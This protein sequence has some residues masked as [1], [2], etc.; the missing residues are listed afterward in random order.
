MCSRGLRCVHVY[1]GSSRYPSVEHGLPDWP[2]HLLL[3]IGGR[4]PSLTQRSNSQTDGKLIDGEVTGRAAIDKEFADEDRRRFMASC[5]EHFLTMH[6]EMKFSGGIIHRLLLREL[7]HNG[8]T[9]EMHFMSGTQSILMGVDERFKIPVWQFRLVKD[10]DAFDAFPWGAYVYRHSIHSFKHALDGRKDGFERRRVETYNIYGLSH[11]LLIFALE[12]IHELAKEVSVWRVTDLT[13]R[14]LKW[15]LTKQPKG[16]KLAKIFKARI[17]A[18]KELVPTPAER[19]APYYACLDEGGALTMRDM[20]QT[21]NEKGIGI[22]GFGFPLPDMNI[23]GVGAVPSPTQHFHPF[24]E[25]PSPT[26]HVRGVGAVPSP[27]LPSKSVPSER[28]PP[29]H[30]TTVSS[31]RSPSPPSTTV[32][33]EL[34]PPP[35]STSVASDRSP[36]PVKRLGK[37]RLQFVSPYTDPCRPKRLKTRPESVEHIF[38]PHRLVDGDHLP[39][40]KAFKRDINGE[41]RDVDVLSPIT[42]GWFVRMQSNFMDLEDTP[43]MLYMWERM[44]PRDSHGA[45]STQGADFVQRW[46]PTLAGGERRPLSRED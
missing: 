29:P 11:A 17:F 46:G 15:E 28:S 3:A 6:R 42:A 33:S 16:K 1:L 37:R 27:P 9:D 30:S 10:L 44:L 38:D 23:C 2:A 19:Q 24:G 41:Q 5:F 31:E 14:I 22:G 18:L 36:P 7:H 12:V 13:P 26:Q 39:A 20:R 32:A 21:L 4:Y 40:Y 43:L 8:P 45:V 25:V 35:P 34:S